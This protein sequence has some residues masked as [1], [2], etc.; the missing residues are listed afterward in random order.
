MSLV[1][2]SG[3]PTCNRKSIPLITSD[4]L[5]DLP[6]LAIGGLDPLALDPAFRHLPSINRARDER[7]LRQLLDGAVARTASASR[8]T[9]E[10]LAAMRDIGI[11]VASLRRLSGDAHV[12]PGPVEESLVHLGAMTNM[13]P[14]ETVIHYCSWNPE[15]ARRRSFTGSPQEEAL[16]SATARCLA[17]FEA[18]ARLLLDIQ[19]RDPATPPFAHACRRAA[20]ELSVAARAVQARGGALDA[21]HF[22]TA[23]RPYFEPVT[24]NGRRYSAAAAAQVPLYIVD[25]CVFGRAAGDVALAELRDELAAYGLP[26]WRSAHQQARSGPSITEAVA[27][28]RS[29]VASRSELLDDTVAAV[30]ALVGQMLSFRSRHRRLVAGAYKHCPG[31]FEVGSAG[32]DLHTVDGLVAATHRQY[33][34]MVHL[35]DGPHGRT[36]SPAIAQRS[37]LTLHSRLVIPDRR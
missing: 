32:A 31:G 13:P 20:E 4:W 36:R 37:R 22:A 33:R 8:S 27:A 16:I 11:L 34:E 17:S 1:T 18:A 26:R 29:R 6:S 10:A 19:G 12:L 30:R 2:G 14:R 3:P 24:I 25:E 35:Q 5:S 23:L 15:G 28:A 7:R 21:H 9:P